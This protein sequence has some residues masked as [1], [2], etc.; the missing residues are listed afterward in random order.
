MFSQFWLSMDSIDLD[1]LMELF[2]IAAT[3]T[4]TMVSRR[5]EVACI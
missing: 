4:Y 3:D 2:P 5:F 1:E